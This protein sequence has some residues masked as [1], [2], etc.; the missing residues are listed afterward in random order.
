MYFDQEAFGTRLKGIR[1]EK[2]M[3][4]E[5]MAEL[6]HTSKTHYGN[7]E[8]GKKGVSIDFLLE[9]AET[10]DKKTDYLLLG[11]EENDL[12]QAIRQLQDAIENL[13]EVVRNMQR[14]I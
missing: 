7:M 12:E 4:Q 2:G 14:G 5:E 8:R 9:I 1:N 13:G 3:S 11:K 6:L 10:F